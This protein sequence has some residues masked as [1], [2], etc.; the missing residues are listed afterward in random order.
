MPRKLCQI[1]VNVALLQYQPNDKACFEKRQI[2]SIAYTLEK[3]VGKLAGKT[4]SEKT[5]HIKLDE[6]SLNKFVGKITLEK[7]RLKKLCSWKNICHNQIFRKSHQNHFY[8]FG[9]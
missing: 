3:L 8:N 6:K 4:S 5:L 1:S 2:T 7:T 9:P